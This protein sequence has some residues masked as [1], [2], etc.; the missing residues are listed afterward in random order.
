MSSASAFGLDASVRVNTTGYTPPQDP[1]A[2]SRSAAIGVVV[3]V[4]LGRPPAPV[5]TGT[6]TSKPPVGSAAKDD[7]AMAEDSDS[8]VL[9]GVV[10]RV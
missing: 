9:L 2:Q 3:D 4:A 7:T 1:R 6:L 5:L 8:G 10:V